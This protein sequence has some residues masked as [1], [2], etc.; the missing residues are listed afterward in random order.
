MNS[1]QSATPQPAPARS[2]TGYARVRKLAGE[3]EVIVSVKSVNHRSLDIHFH[4]S[5]DLDPLETEMRALV[6][7]RLTRGHVEVRVALAGGTASARPAMNRA[8]LEAYMAGFEEAAAQ[9]SL[10]GATPDLN[11]A[12]RVAGMFGDTT[13]REIGASLNQA[14]LT[15]LSEALDQL[16]TCASVKL[17]NW[18]QRCS[19]TMTVSVKPR[20]NWRAS[21]P[22]RS[23]V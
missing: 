21:V 8:L 14:I 17:R 20:R 6:R 4:C 10:T 13:E 18:F 7:R 15:A 2:M 9:Y 16:S 5:S 19:A 22:A 12:F 23:L 11:A 3:T 1:S